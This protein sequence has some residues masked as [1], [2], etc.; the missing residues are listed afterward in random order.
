[1]GLVISLLLWK[2]PSL[3]KGR[4]ALADQLAAPPSRSTE[5][6]LAILK[7]PA[8][9]EHAETMAACVL[10]M[11]VG[12]VANCSKVARKT[13]NLAVSLLSLLAAHR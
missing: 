5:E 4:E 10:S 8:S 9:P 2:H 11:L 1:M 6:H 3:A 7:K 12:L 13:A